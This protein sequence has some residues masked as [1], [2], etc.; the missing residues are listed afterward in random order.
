MKS[1]AQDS[2]LG[3]SRAEVDGI[4]DYTPSYYLTEGEAM[5]GN[6]NGVSFLQFQFQQT[7]APFSETARVFRKLQLFRGRLTLILRRRQMLSFQSEQSRAG[8]T[9]HFMTCRE[10]RQNDSGLRY[11]TNKD[12]LPAAFACPDESLDFDFYSLEKDCADK[13]YFTFQNEWYRSMFP[14]AVHRRF[15]YD[16]WHGCDR[17]MKITNG[18][19]YDAGAYR[20]GAQYYALAVKRVVILRH[21]SGFCVFRRIFRFAFRRFKDDPIGLESAVWNMPRTT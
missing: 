14:A 6:F 18:V 8:V 9:Y 11:Y 4:S 5:Y 16:A 10:A 7:D 21:D 13:N 12:V 19:T 20:T 3:A 1:A 17:R 2:A 15:L